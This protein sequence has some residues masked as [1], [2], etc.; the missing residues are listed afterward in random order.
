MNEDLSTIHQFHNL[1]PWSLFELRCPSSLVSCWTPN[2][3]NYIIFSLDFTNNCFARLAFL[4]VIFFHFLSD[5]TKILFSLENNFK[6]QVRVRKWT[7][8]SIDLSLVKL[9]TKTLS[10]ADFRHMKVD[11][12]S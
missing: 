4:V 3:I 11:W 5:L 6:M 10:R 7:K 1:F 12:K 8:E 2:E 9:K